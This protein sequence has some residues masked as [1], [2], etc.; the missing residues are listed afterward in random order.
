[1]LTVVGCGNLVRRDDS[2]GVRLAQR[3]AS[4]LADHP[5]AGVQ[6][7]DCGTAGFEVM[8]RA[9]GSTALVIVDAAQTGAAPGTIYEVPGDVVAA[10]TM[11]EVNLHA[12]R[13]DHAIG[14]GR[15]VYKDE[16]P[17][18]VQVVLIEVADTSYGEELSPAVE[19]AADEVYRRLLD[20]VAAHAATH[21]AAQQAPLVLMAERGSLQMPR[22]V[23]ERV[24]GDRTSAAVLPRDAALVLLPVYAEQGGVLVKQ[25]NLRGDRAIEL[26]DALRN[27]GWDDA[28][29]VALVAVPDGELGGLILTRQSETP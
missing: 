11:P 25:K 2:V 3:L 12:F 22:D 27:C 26:R 21:A 20:R 29:T 5:I 4:R 28:G 23:F 13:W 17:A 1:M 7:I 16:F 9:R 8:Y 19:R 10:V 15:A 6:A 24:F 18:D 14:V